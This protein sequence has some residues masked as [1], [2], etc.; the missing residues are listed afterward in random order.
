LK[1][2][3]ILIGTMVITATVLGAGAVFARSASET[4]PAVQATH[5]TALAVHTAT[6]LK[7]HGAHLRH[8]ARPHRHLAQL[9][10]MPVTRTLPHSM[11]PVPRHHERRAALPPHQVRAGRDHSGSRSGLRH[12]AATSSDG[13]LLT[14]SVQRLERL[15]NRK[16]QSFGEWVTSGRGP[17]RAGPTSNSVPLPY[18]G[19][20][21]T[22]WSALSLLPTIAPHDRSPAGASAC[23]M[24]GA[25]APCV[26]D[27]STD[28]P[29]QL[30][31]R[32]HTDRRE[33]AVVCPFM[34]SSGEST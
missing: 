1:R 20:C 4:T 24:R 6:G 30:H 15:Q 18:A 11:P 7:H 12:M 8:H 2:T 3:Q 25:S 28:E 10:R 32:S 19:P 13:G 17:P 5:A 33:G 34:P 9:S 29:E 22:L 23:R 31:G 14:V 26:A 27:R 21:N 16:V